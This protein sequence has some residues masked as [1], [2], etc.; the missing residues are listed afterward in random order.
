M[1]ENALRNI[2]IGGT[3]LFM[4]VLIG[5]TANTIQQ[6]SNVRTPQLTDAVVAGKIVWQN[7]N[8]NDCHTVLGIGGYFAPDLT[9]AITR[10]GAPWITSWLANPQVM[11]PGTTMPNQ[12]LGT[13]DISNLTAFLTWVD[14]VD[15]NGWPPQ[16]VLNAQPTPGPTPFGGQPVSPEVAAL[17]QKGSCGGCHTIP[18][19]ITAVGTAGPNWCVPA[20]KFQSGTVDQAYIRR[21]ITDPNA[22]IAAG[23][24][25]NIMPQDYSKQFTSQEIDM[26]VTFITGLKCQ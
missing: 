18:G 13:T 12:R 10:R 9:K 5:M 22:D 1:S 2:F 19:I 7:K 4:V 14:K 20:Q 3:V 15:T 17:V 24:S 21:A 25:P 6:V 11:I 26:L 8:C 23:Y 16:P